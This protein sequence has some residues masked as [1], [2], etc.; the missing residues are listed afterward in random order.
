MRDPLYIP[1]PTRHRS[2]QA[3]VRLNGKDH[4]LGRHGSRQAAAASEAL[5]AHWLANGRQLPEAGDDLTVNDLLLVYDRWAENYY[6]RE[7]KEDTHL[8]MIRDALRVVK[9]LFGRGPAADFSPRKLKQVQEAMAGQGWSR[10]YVNEQVNR[11]RRAFKWAVAEELVPGDL[12][13]AL[14]AVPALRKGT[15]GV[16]ETEPVKPVPEAFVNAALPFMPVPIRVMVRAQLLTGMRPGEV[17]IMRAC[18]LDLSGRV[19]IYRPSAHKTEHHGKSRE[20][21]LGPQAQAVLRPWLTL[22]TQAYLF[23][24]AAAGAARNEARRRSRRTPMTPSQAKRRPKANPKRAKRDHY[25]ETSYRNA[26]YRACDRAFPPPAPLA[27]QGRVE[28]GLAGPSDSGTAGGTEPLACRPP[29][30]PEPTPPQRR[31]RHPQGTRHRDGPHHPG[32][33]PGVHDRN[34]RGDRPAAG[35]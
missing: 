1:K 15:R 13:H 25:D 3:V 11:V 24:P 35:D 27:P 17:C 32:P 12:H 28:G 5:I 20:V 4:Y 34:L 22:D 23:S 26:V 8:G 21:Y 30:A 19:W 2:G 9:N 10:N 14:R 18:D 6:H 33:Q 31:D 29:L 7:G 16:R